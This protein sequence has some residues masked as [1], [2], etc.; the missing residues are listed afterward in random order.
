[1]LAVERDLTVHLQIVS[2][3]SM[4]SNRGSGAAS[5]LTTAATRESSTLT[6]ASLS[7]HGHMLLAFSRLLF[8]K[9]NRHNPTP[10]HEQPNCEVSLPSMHNMLRDQ[11][12]FI[13][14]KVETVSA[15]EI[16]G[17]GMGGHLQMTL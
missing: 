11:A 15:R 2:S 7:V 12:T 16:W 10:K 6:I 4:I 3:L 5:N 9:E 17:V 13:V 14:L 1:M 8:L